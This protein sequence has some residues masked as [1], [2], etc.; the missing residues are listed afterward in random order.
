MIEFLEKYTKSKFTLDRKQLSKIDLMLDF[1]FQHTNK[2]LEGSKNRFNMR[3]IF[4]SWF[5]G[6]TWPYHKYKK[7]N[8]KI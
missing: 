8:F 6:K 1:I 4:K 5:L 7:F 3:S 2:N